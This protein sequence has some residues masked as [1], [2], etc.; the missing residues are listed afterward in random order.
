MKIQL[1]TLIYEREHV[2]NCL[3][4]MTSNNSST[5][6]TGLLPPSPIHTH[7]V[8]DWDPETRENKLLIDVDPLVLAN[9]PDLHQLLDS[10]KGEEEVGRA[11]GG[12]YATFKSILNWTGFLI[13]KTLEIA[14]EVLV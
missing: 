5:G 10:L 2:C 12:H 8:W 11:K 14:V 7:K 4:Q 6:F 13:L 1:V 9:D 3:R